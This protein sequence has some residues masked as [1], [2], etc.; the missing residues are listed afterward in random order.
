MQ[1]FEISSFYSYDYSEYL[2]SELLILSLK[3][4]KL[5]KAI[6]ALLMRV[7]YYD[8]IVGKY[9]FTL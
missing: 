6:Y 2:P 8:E 1:L 4:I 5:Q 3:L 9:T 7:V